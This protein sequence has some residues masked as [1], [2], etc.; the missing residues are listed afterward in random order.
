MVI[1]FVVI[2]GIVDHHCLEVVICFVDIGWIDN[3]HCLDVVIC[4]VDIGWIENHQF[5][6]SY[7]VFLNIGWIDDHYCWE[8]VIFLLILIEL[9]TI[10]VERFIC[11]VDIGWIDGHYCL[12]VHLFCWYWLNRWPSLLRGSFV[13][14]ILV[15]LMAITVERFICFV[16]IGWIGGHHRLSFFP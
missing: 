2:G 12:E 6:G 1:C 16:D 10:T 5:I 11:F 15:E 4:F 7:L 14:L 9:M 13:L 8:V 3:H